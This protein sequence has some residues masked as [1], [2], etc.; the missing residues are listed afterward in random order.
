MSAR[1]TQSLDA[2]GRARGIFQRGTVLHPHA[3][4]RFEI[5]LLVG[6][7]AERLV[8]G[9]AAT[10]E[11]EP[12][13]GR[14]LEFVPVLVDQPGGPVNPVGAIAANED[15]NRSALAFRHNAASVARRRRAPTK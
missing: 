3:G 8:L 11:R 7:I 15:R 5:N 6:A 4:F 2:S 12:V 13:A 14:D 9:L 10:A 1:F